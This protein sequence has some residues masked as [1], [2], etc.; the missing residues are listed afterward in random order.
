MIAKHVGDPVLR[1]CVPIEDPRLSNFK[2]CNLNIDQRTRT[3][4]DP[5]TDTIELTVTAARRCTMA[6]LQPPT[7]DTCHLH[8]VNQLHWGTAE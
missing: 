1:H 4:R 6:L 2:M 7:I 8:N 3:H 5:G